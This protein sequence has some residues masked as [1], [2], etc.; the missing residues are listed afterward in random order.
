M[1]F[2]LLYLNIIYLLYVIKKKK[3]ENLGFHLQDRSLNSQ[4]FTPTYLK[5]TKN[6]P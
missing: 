6:L 3:I 4:D 5:L 1:L 2:L